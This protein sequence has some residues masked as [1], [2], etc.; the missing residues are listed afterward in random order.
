MNRIF[1]YSSTFLGCYLFYA[2]ILLL[3]FFN[4]ISINLSTTSKIMAIYDMLIVLVVN[5]RMIH[6]GASI[7]NEFTENKLQLLKIKKDFQFIKI[8]MESIMCGDKKLI[9]ANIK[10]YVRLF[11]IHLK[12][13]GSIEE[14]QRYTSDLIDEIDTI[15]ERLDIEGT[16]KPLSLLGIAATYS[17]LKTIYTSLLTVMFAVA[18]KLAT[19]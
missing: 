3:E 6:F 5:L 16:N 11:R 1:I 19:S 10:Q 13:L 17:V 2:V 12:K 15:I 4:L 18:Q 8:N 7:N 9:G 14:T